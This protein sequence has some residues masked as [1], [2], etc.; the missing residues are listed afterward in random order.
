MP[1]AKIKAMLQHDHEKTAEIIFQQGVYP[2]KYIE[3]AL[4]LALERLEK[5]NSYDDLNDFTLGAYGICLQHYLED[6]RVESL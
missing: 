6:K 4:S 2:A 3:Y 1:I 5:C